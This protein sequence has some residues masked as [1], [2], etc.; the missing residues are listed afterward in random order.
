MKKAHM[1]TILLMHVSWAFS[2]H[3]GTVINNMLVK[4]IK[5]YERKNLL[6]SG[7]DSVQESL[8]E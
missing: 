1:F 7:K 5:K 2:S 4:S 6:D 3:D 8:T